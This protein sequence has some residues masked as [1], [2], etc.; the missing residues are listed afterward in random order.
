M[1]DLKTLDAKGLIADAYAIDGISEP[2]C[3]SIF[4]DWAISV[5]DGQTPA[6]LLPLLSAHYAD[7]DPDHPM[8][9]VLAE[10]ASQAHAKPAR[11]GGAGG[12]RG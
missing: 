8:S 10:G 1:P 5:P 11:R 9:R 4:L 12:R 2:E 7:R 3:R 6:S